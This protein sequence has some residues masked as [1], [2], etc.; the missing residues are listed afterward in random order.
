LCPLSLPFPPLK[1]HGGDNGSKPPPPC[2]WYRYIH[3]LDGHGRVPSTRSGWLAVTWRVVTFSIHLCRYVCSS[4]SPFRTTIPPPPPLSH[5]EKKKRKKERKKTS[6]FG[7]L[8]KHR[9]QSARVQYVLRMYITD[10]LRSRPSSPSP[11]SERSDR[12]DC[13]RSERPGLSRGDRWEGKASLRTPEEIPFLRLGNWG[14]GGLISETGDRERPRVH[15][16]V[17]PKKRGGGG[18]S[19]FAVA[20]SRAAGRERECVCV[21]S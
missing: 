12:G 16:Y 15:I 5:Q 21:L 20:G 19:V 11:F 2:G 9:T 6:D 14:G 13:W 8:R 3:S 17:V 7:V 10:Q 18:G 4:V 1:V